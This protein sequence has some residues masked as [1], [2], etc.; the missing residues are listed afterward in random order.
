[1]GYGV[2]KPHGVSRLMT[3]VVWSDRLYLMSNTHRDKCLSKFTALAVVQAVGKAEPENKCQALERIDLLRQKC[4][5][6]ECIRGED[7]AVKMSVSRIDF[8]S[9]GTR[10][11]GVR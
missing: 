6:F 10:V 11:V 5:K 1:M 2:K 9:G 3:L 8:A 4:R 7:S